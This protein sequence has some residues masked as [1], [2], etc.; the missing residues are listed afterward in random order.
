MFSVQFSFTWLTAH[1]AG[2]SRCSRC[3]RCWLDVYFGVLRS[4]L[5]ALVACVLALRSSLAQTTLLSAPMVCC[6]TGCERWCTP[7][8]HVHSALPLLAVQWRRLELQP[9]L[10]WCW[11]YGS[12]CHRGYRGHCRSG[13]YYGEMCRAVSGSVAV[14]LD[15]GQTFS[16]LVQHLVVVIL[17]VGAS[18]RLARLE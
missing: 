5:L 7:S 11:P 16:L 1:G 12:R 8:T 3:S 13:V 9:S 2:C 14:C 17:V 4:P 18:V 15:L 6:C 10:C